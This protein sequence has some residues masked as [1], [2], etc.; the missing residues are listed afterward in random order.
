[1][2]A[3]VRRARLH[4]RVRDMPLHGNV[5]LVPHGLTAYD[6]PVAHAKARVLHW[7]A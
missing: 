1:M 2:S 5:W 3:S 6:K 4:T 7:S